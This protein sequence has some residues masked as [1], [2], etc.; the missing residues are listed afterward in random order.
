M[1]VLAIKDQAR[2]SIDVIDDENFLKAVYL[3][4]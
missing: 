4:L 1:K 3:I 2:Q